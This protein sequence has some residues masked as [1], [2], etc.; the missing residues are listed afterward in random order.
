MFIAVGRRNEEESG[1]S[2]QIKCL[3]A[4]T[5]I[6]SLYCSDTNAVACLLHFRPFGQMIKPMLDSMQVTPQ[7]GHN[8]IRQQQQS[9]VDSTAASGAN[10]QPAAA[11]NIQSPSVD[12]DPPQSTAAMQLPTFKVDSVY[13]IYNKEKKNLEGKCSADVRKL[14]DEFS[15]YTATPQPTWSPSP[16]HIKAFGKVIK[17]TLFL[18]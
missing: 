4:N 7:G 3:R 9:A 6:V 2:R 5:K 1:H 8:V 11:T 18:L 12:R 16:A 13:E 14:L 15:E 17:T 10:N